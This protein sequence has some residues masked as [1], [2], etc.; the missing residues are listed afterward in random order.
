MGNVIRREEF[1]ELWANSNPTEIAKKYEVSRMRVYHI[2]KTFGLKPRSQMILESDEGA[3]SEDEI[4]ERAAAIR[5]R[6]SDEEERKRRV[7]N[8]GTGRKWTAPEIRVGD[9]EAPSFSRI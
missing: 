5:E 4:L 9:I 8:R 6:W 2:A 3:P 1:E 7:G